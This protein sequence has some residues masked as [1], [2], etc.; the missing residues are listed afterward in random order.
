MLDP[1]IFNLQENVSFG[2]GVSVTVDVLGAKTA[3]LFNDLGNYA[4]ISMFRRH[5]TES[6]LEAKYSAPE[7]FIQNLFYTKLDVV[8]C[9][10]YMLFPSFYSG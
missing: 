7:Y 2:G 3:P 9:Y 8:F 1:F 4:R 6:T 10:L 5:G